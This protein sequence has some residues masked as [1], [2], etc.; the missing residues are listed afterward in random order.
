MNTKALSSVLIKK[1]DDDEYKFTTQSNHVHDYLSFDY[2]KISKLNS[3][4][5]LNLNVNIRIQ[6]KLIKYGRC[7]QILSDGSTNQNLTE[8][9]NDDQMWD[10][11]FTIGEVGV[12]SLTTKYSPTY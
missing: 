2:F 7:C 6:N 3:N 1:R 9:I 12:I 11:I 8:L 5:N 10:Q 4:T